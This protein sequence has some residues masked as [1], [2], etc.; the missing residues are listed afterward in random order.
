MT[1]AAAKYNVLE[2][3]RNRDQK[4][5]RLLAARLDGREAYLRDAQLSF[6]AAEEH[7]AYTLTELFGAV[8]PVQSRET[9]AGGIP[10]T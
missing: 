3:L 5:D 2:A 10:E 4:R 6:D 7:F 9:N 1:P 8:S